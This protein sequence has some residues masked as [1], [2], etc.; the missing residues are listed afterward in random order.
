[1]SSGGKT[2]HRPNKKADKGPANRIRNRGVVDY[3]EVEIIDSDTSGDH[4]LED[5]ELGLGRSSSVSKNLV[6]RRKGVKGFSILGCPKHL[7]RMFIR[8]PNKLLD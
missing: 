2:A 3:T 1:M 6:R 5:S 8:C 7:G 4:T